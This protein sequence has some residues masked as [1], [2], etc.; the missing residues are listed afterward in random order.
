MLTFKFKAEYRVS[1]SRRTQ[2]LGSFLFLFVKLRAPQTSNYCTTVLPAVA[3]T[4][5]QWLN[6]Q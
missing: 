6:E 2:R 4:A 5:P 1:D 3:A